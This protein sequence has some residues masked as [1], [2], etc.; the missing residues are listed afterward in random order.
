MSLLGLDLVAV[1]QHACSLCTG[2]IQRRPT[3]TSPSSTLPMHSSA[4]HAS[5]NRAETTVEHEFSSNTLVT[6]GSFVTVEEGGVFNEI[7]THPR[8][9]TEGLKG[10]CW[11]IL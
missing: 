4:G 1:I 7:H 9:G 11:A 8:T 6:G 2:R 5:I 3:S 10:E